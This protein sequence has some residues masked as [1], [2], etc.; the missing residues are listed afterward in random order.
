MSAEIDPMAEIRASFF[1]ECEELLEALQDGLET[2]ESGE[3]DPEMINV[4]FRAVHSI[5]GG[6]GA[7]GLEA[8]VRFA[9]RY[10]TVLDEV[11]AGRMVV[12]GGAL[13]VFFQAADHLSDLVKIS[14]DGA[15]LP[16]AETQTLLGLLDGFLGS[17]VKADN[18][19]RDIE[20]QPMG[21]ALDLG[22]YDDGEPEIDEPEHAALPT[23]DQ[24]V[25]AARQT[26]LIEFMP[27]AGFF[28][29]GNE[30]ALLLRNLSAL[31]D[32]TVVL[33]TD[34]LPEFANISPVVPHLCWQISL[35]TN[36]S[37][38]DILSVFDFVE[39]LCK[40]DV[41]QSQDDATLQPEPAPLVT[42]AAV[43]TT[44]SEKKQPNAA[45]AKSVVRVD[46]DR[47]ERLVNLVGELVINQAMLSQ[48]LEQSGLSPHSDAM[49]GLEE[50]Q[51]LTR[52]IQDSVMMI[53]AQPVKSLFQRMSRIIREASSAINKEV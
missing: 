34:Q 36:G 14:C 28:E 33:D 38:D 39:G 20:F 23:L 53:R 7:F 45:L 44:A 3:D 42:P 8:L 15:A 21:I 25:H 1:I 40:L 37:R 48:S 30:A 43:N 13:K 46:L 22:F 47:I 32:A 50:F 6:A 12:S 4:V 27:A 26:F 51:R 5:K 35:K 10:E 52:D 24:P 29:T 41:S 49:N 17:E 16:D 9:H 2:I 31:G 19:E 11:R 18:D